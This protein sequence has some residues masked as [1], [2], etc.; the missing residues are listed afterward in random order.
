MVTLLGAVANAQDLGTV[1]FSPTTQQV[2]DAATGTDPGRIAP[3]P[4][5]DPIGF[6]IQAWGNVRVV[7]QSNIPVPFELIADYTSSTRGAVPEVVLSTSQQTVFDTNWGGRF[8]NARVSV[9]YWL[10]L[11]GAVPAGTYTVMV[12]YTLIGA[13]SVTNTIRVTVPPMLA[14]R[15]SGGD[16][17]AFDYASSPQNYFAAIGGTLPPTVAGTTLTSVDVW[18]AGSYSLTAVLSLAATGPSLPTGAIRLKGVPLGASPSVVATGSGTAGGFVSVIT[19]S[20]FAL[21]IT[22]QEQPGSFDAVVT[23]T[24]TSP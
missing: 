1:T 4:T 24:V 11:T 21:A 6:T 3:D 19:P 20:D 17:V 8:R 13:N 23:Y 7:V 10:H 14:L 22:G 5:S 9:N 18:S 16:T 15:I 2:Y 12:T